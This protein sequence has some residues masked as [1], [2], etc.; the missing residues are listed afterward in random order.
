[1]IQVERRGDV[2]VLRVDDGRVNALDVEALELL[3]ATLHPLTG[4]VVITGNGRVFS[5]GVDLRRVLAEGPEYAGRLLTALTRAL[6]AVFD[7]PGPTVA[8]LD[9]PAIAGG[10]VLAL[11]CDVRLA[12]TGPIGLTELGVGVPYPRAALEIARYALGPAVHRLVL[13]AETFDL[14]EALRLGLADEAV[15]RE[16]LLDRAVALAS[17]LA[18]R[19]LEAYA[20]AKHQLHAPVETLLADADDVAA[21]AMWSAPETRERIGAALSRLSSAGGRHSA[22]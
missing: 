13:Q 17:E 6:R 9:G 22:D 1:V 14:D 11:A 10:C 5:A 8:A 7:H 3:A 15:P 21:A 12:V 18:A 2:H 20:L 4:A 19:S 16:Q